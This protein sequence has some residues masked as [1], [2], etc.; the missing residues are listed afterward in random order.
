MDLSKKLWLNI[1]A[2]ARHQKL[3]RSLL[4]RALAGIGINDY[5]PRQD[6]GEEHLLN[7]MVATLPKGA[8]VC[9]IGAHSG[10]Y[11]TFLASKRPDLVIHAFE[12]NPAIFGELAKN[13]ANRFT[14]HAF[15][16]GDAEG[17]AML[18]D[19]KASGGSECASLVGDAVDE[20]YS[21]EVKLTVPVKVKTLDSVA[22]TNS[23]LRIDYLKIDAE[24]Y[25]LMVLK[26]ASSLIAADKLGVVQFEFNKMNVF[27]RTFMHDF[28][29]LLPRHKLHRI[30]QDGL[31]PLGKYDPMTCEF[32]GYQNIVAIPDAMAV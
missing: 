17:E 32:F 5:G 6:R 7:R 19:P 24:G 30:V 21:N 12:P 1:F 22:R 2:R 27:S 11:A 16:L 26:G 14:A 8:I 29:Q 18:H 9:D 20:L 28:Y 23:L 15:A 31:V 3:N 4:R 13:S 25:D 10:S